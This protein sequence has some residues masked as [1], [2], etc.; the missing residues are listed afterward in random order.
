MPP[1]RY[2]RRVDPQTVFR[3]NLTEDVEQDRIAVV[4]GTGFSS[5][6][7]G[8]ATCASWV[9]LLRDGVEFVY[10]LEGAVKR[11]FL[12]VLENAYDTPSLLGAAQFI[13]SKFQGLEGEY[14]D[15]LDRT[16]GSLEAAHPAH[17]LDAIPDVE[18]LLTTN[19]DTLW[20]EKFNRTPI[21]WTENNSKTRYFRDAERFVYHL[22]GIHS[23]P[24]SVIFSGHDYGRLKEQGDVP[25][26][27]HQVAT[28]HSLLLI[29]YGQG[30]DD[31]NFGPFMEWLVSE[32][33]TAS[34]RHYLLI[35]SADEANI[36]IR[37][38]LKGRLTPIVYGDKYED[39]PKFLSAL[40][41]RTKQEEKAV[42]LVG[43]APTDSPDLSDG[44]LRAGLPR[45]FVDLLQ[46]EQFLGSFGALDKFQARALS[47]ILELVENQRSALF[48][49]VTGTGK[50]TLARVAMNLA[51]AR[52][53]SAVALMP[54]KALVSQERKVWQIWQSFWGDIAEKRVT[55]YAASRDY[56]EA[57]RPVSRG[58][59]D[60]AVAIY[61]KLALY[62]I[63]GHEPLANT[64]VLVVDELQILAENSERS[65][66]LE[67][68][69]TMIRLLAPDERPT[70]LGL[71][72]TLRSESTIALQKWLGVEEDLVVQTNERPV[73]LDAFVVSAVDQMK[74][75]D[76]HLIG[77]KGR[78]APAPSPVERHDLSD[79]LA[80]YSKQLSDRLSRRNSAQLAAVL[81]NRLL[82]EDDDRKI[83]CFVS[84]RGGADALSSAIQ[85][86]LRKRLGRAG[87]GSPWQHGRFAVERLD[88]D[89][90]QYDRLKFSALPAKDDVI[91]GLREGV[92]AHS[93]TY[94]SV[95]RRLIEDEFSRPDGLLRVLVATD[96]LAM[97]VNL[98]ADTVIATSVS[99]YSGDGLK[100][101]LSAENIA[102]KA[103]R[104]GRR[105][106]SR[107]PRGEFYLVVPSKAELQDVHGLSNTDMDSVSTLKGILSTY[108]GE[109]GP[110]PAVKSQY[111]TK[112]DVASLSLQ[113][114]CQDRHG[115]TEENTLL[116]LTEV[117]DGMLSKHEEKP[118]SWEPRDI[119]DE[120]VSRDL[121]GVRI[122]DGLL[123]LSGLGMALGT[124]SLDLDL[125][126]SLERIARLST[127]NAG[128]IDLLWNACRSSAIQQST[129]WVSLPPAH[130]RHGPS[131]RDAV[132]ELG[133]AYCHPELERRQ[134]SAQ[135]LQLGRYS[136]PDSVIG[137]GSPVVSK[138]LL[139]LLAS[140]GE[141]S[142]DAEVTALLR[143][144]VLNEWSLGI[145]FDDIKARL[146][147]AV[148]TREE[149]GKS[150]VVQLR[151]HYA[152]VEQIADQVA[153]VLRGASALALGDDGRDYSMQVSALAAEVEMGVP[154]WMV[155]LLRLRLP[156]LHRERLAPWWP[157]QPPERLVDLLADPGI[158]ENPGVSPG[159]LDDAVR[160]LE[161]RAVEEQATRHRVAGRWSSVRVPGGEGDSFGDIA[162]ELGEAASSSDYGDVLIRVLESMRLNV[163]NST[164]DGF[165][166]S[167]RVTSDSGG[168]TLLVPHAD[169]T[170]ESLLGVLERDAVLIARTRLTESG[171][172]VLRSPHLLR[173]VEPEH[174]ITLLARLVEVRGPG[175]HPDEVVEVL[176]GIQ[177]S[178]LESESWPIYDGALRMPPP[179]V[180]ALPPLDPAGPVAAPDEDTAE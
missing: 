131:L 82:A 16:V 24:P 142:S 133:N 110:S 91:C 180:G 79:D 34:H 111:R 67:A 168:V 128:R 42:D 157:E 108:I 21:T 22:H 36:D 37:G 81:V 4:L 7:S 144:I 179:F 73:P 158:S 175:V 29:G 159:D 123:S 137:Q 87:R 75:V 83:I 130:R 162:E 97:G 48:F 98:P 18:Y 92:C 136:L 1:N 23:D 163:E 59:F 62:M 115:R 57:D 119:L 41:W 176:V 145:P 117:L 32:Q 166:Q 152:D 6:T 64:T 54:T 177:V 40:P 68:L 43:S 19:Y 55:I 141:H 27:L 138:E 61:E 102:N 143:A 151:L 124:S 126:S 3:N 129:P 118:L 80:A 160:L 88:A 146:T 65:A 70:I 58:R 25:A 44:L 134:L 45:A 174:L 150:E 11:P 113:V 49:T 127:A 28:S 20:Q 165:H 164:D 105:G 38:K 51:V 132:I 140:D 135:R 95:L 52:G 10:G 104:A 89:A 170:G 125:A 33:G 156:T 171:R 169:I 47:A 39:L 96:T 35:R 9:G 26:V 173:A 93:A 50:T 99:G 139:A 147:A 107:R 167:I 17:L 106:Q 120:L 8:G 13:S 85:A 31:P 149:V 178:S 148:T 53:S 77:M 161:L 84:T 72:P 114:L 103:G 66:K 155:P 90:G 63:T 69:L 154:A 46:T 56:P 121:I 12:D 15:W 14:A 86:I 94:P 109:V 5:A 78:V 76:A 153:G 30:L 60:V 101:L 112:K 74:Q 100:R 122:R 172:G 71:S 2:S 116:R